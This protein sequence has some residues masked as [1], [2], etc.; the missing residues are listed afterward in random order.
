MSM[1]VLSIYAPAFE[2]Y[3]IRS[4]IDAEPLIKDPKV[5]EVAKIFRLQEAQHS[6]CHQAHIAALVQRYPGLEETSNKL[7]ALIDELYQTENLKF[8]LGFGAVLE[9]TFTPLFKLLIDHRRGLFSQGDSRVASMLLWHFSEEVEHRS[10]AMMVYND[11]VGEHWYRIRLIPTIIRFHVEVNK[12]AV[13]GFKKHVP[14]LPAECFTVSPFRTAP[15]YAQLGTLFG[16]AN[17]QMP[18]YDHETQSLPKWCFKWFEHYER[19]EDMTHF[20]GVKS[21]RTL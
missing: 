3:L 18:W 6:K 5:R 9:A 2:K 17:A 21:G 19:G 15:W 12:I 10:A 4:M 7:F 16:L 20:Y 11:V 13:E 1:N 14:D 8:H